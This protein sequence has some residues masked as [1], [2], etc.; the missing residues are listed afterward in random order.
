MANSY[1][2]IDALGVID[3]GPDS[4]IPI[5]QHAMPCICPECPIP[6]GPPTYQ[7][8][9]KAAHSPFSDL[10][11]EG[12]RSGRRS[13]ILGASHTPAAVDWVIGYDLDGSAIY[14]NP[15][16]P[17]FWIRLKGNGMWITREQ[18]EFPGIT[19]ASLPSFR[20]EPLDTIEV[21]GTAFPKT[22]TSDIHNNPDI[23]GMLGLLG[24]HSN[25]IPLGL[26]YYAPMPNDPAPN[27]PKVCSVMKTTA[28]RRYE[29]NVSAGLE[30]IIQDTLAT[31]DAL[32]MYQ[33]VA[34]VYPPHRSR[35]SSDYFRT[36]QKVGGLWKYSTNAMVLSVMGTTAAGEIETLHDQDIIQRGEIIPSELVYA[37]IP[38]DIKLS[39]G[40][41]LRTMAKL[42]GR[43]GWEAGRCTAV[44]HRCGFDWGTYQDHSSDSMLDNAHANNIVII[45]EELM[46]LGGGKYQLLF[47]T[48]FD[49]SFKRHQ[50]VNTWADPPTPLPEFVDRIYSVEIGNMM[51][52]LAGY[53]AALPDVATGISKR[54][55]PPSPQMDVIWIFRDCAVWEFLKAY[56]AP[57]EARYAGNDITL[58]QC[59]DF[60]PE[61]LA[62]TIDIVV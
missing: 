13:T 25:N 19:L 45:P 7:L 43:L 37:A 30:L 61:A 24:L 29:S 52:N 20:H 57:A 11:I 50:A 27:I 8:P 35:P 22:A 4:P 18:F 38:E 9:M 31:G 14:P 32:R 48:D 36:Y 39:N 6:D 49:M 3:A 44:V 58:E 60:L 23:N 59:L 2:A 54:D 62:R 47:P 56:K 51:A 5:V 28:D 34:P 21:R 17:E 33:A 55:P 10:K 42:F 53:T 41:S 16:A 1:Q 15:D 26:W 40:R 46:D 12:F